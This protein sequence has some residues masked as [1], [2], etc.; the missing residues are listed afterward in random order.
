MK[1]WY[2][3]RDLIAGIFLLIF[4]GWVY[5][6]T[7]KIPVGKISGMPPTFFPSFLAITLAVLSVL[8]IISAIKD[9]LRKVKHEYEEQDI[10]KVVLLVLSI[11][12]YTILL[13]YIGFIYTTIL[14]LVATITLLKGGR[15]I[16]TIPI[17]IIISVS[18]YYIF[19]NF[20]RIP[21][22]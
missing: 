22:P 11:V 20:F 21:L 19:G 8:L 6:T 3:N 4:S 15:L 13:K 18:V 17:A 16:K 1:N 12:F 14:Y 10:I 7:Q 9:I 2:K 5:F